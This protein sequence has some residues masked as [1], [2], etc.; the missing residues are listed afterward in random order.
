MARLSRVY[1][2]PRNTVS[3]AIGANIT[4]ESIGISPA[5]SIMEALWLYSSQTSLLIGRMPKTNVIS[6]AKHI[7]IML[8][9]TY[10]SAGMGEA[11]ISLSRLFLRSAKN[12]NSTP[13]VHTLE[14]RVIS[15]ALAVTPS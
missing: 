2:S 9:G 7:P 12:A 4:V 5:E 11:F 3:S 1:T 8:S 10:V 13:T 15:V 6:T 14:T